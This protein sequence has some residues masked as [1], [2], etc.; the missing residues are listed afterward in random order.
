MIR[1]GCQRSRAGATAGRGQEDLHPF[2][3]LVEL[4]GT[5]AAEANAFFEATE[6]FFE[7]KVAPFQTFNQHAQTRKDLVELDRLGVWRGGFRGHEGL[8]SS[9]LCGAGRSISAPHPG[10]YPVITL[11]NRCEPSTGAIV[12]ASVVNQGIAKPDRK[13]SGRFGLR[14]QI[15]LGLAAVTLIAIL[16]T[17]FLALWAAGAT[18]GVHRETEAVTLTSAAARMVSA[19]VDRQTDIESSESREQLRA[20]LSTLSERSGG[21]QFSV[22]SAGRGVVASWPPRAARDVDPPIANSVVAGSP[23]VIQYR[24]S[25]GGG[26]TQLLAY[27]GI[28]ARGRIVGA[29][30][31]VLDA[32]PPVQVVLRRSGWL[33]LGLVCGDALL[34]LALGYFVLTQMVVRPLR[35][36][37]QATA[38]VGVGDWDQHIDLPGPS[39][40]SALARAFN[41]MTSSLAAQREQLI[42]SEKLAS[43]GQLAAGVAHEIGNPLAAILGYV[44]ILRADL[45]G[46]G[47]L[48]EAERRDALD[49]V[50]A[51]TQRINRII[52]DLLE[53]SRPSHEEPSLVDPLAVVRSAQAL[54]A[55]QARLREVRMT[56][57]P[58]AGPWPTVMVSQ[59]RMTQVLVNL[60]LNA[61]DAMSGKGQVAITCERAAG[62]V[63]IA[64]SDEGPGIERELRR[65]VFDP[66]FTTKPPGQGTGLGLSI[67]R[68][69]VESYGGT[70]ELD[71]EAVRGARFVVDLPAALDAYV[72]PFERT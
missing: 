13:R 53:Y 49:R 55:P 24:D 61:A 48:P 16:T 28:E 69:I 33:L 11:E 71:A 68:S 4:L 64:V 6:P 66:F 32:P 36:M 35:K 21:I 37:E 65:K 23:P 3:R 29:A 27:A 54:L 26:A 1:W 63:R 5:A 51:E 42:R 56:V 31:V 45:A 44:D 50:K 34:V 59:G 40:L 7:S 2:F 9:K 22:L 60:L 19:I 62:R 46:T 25:P 14:A 17:G 43:V 10:P 41:Q 18:L 15:L 58:Q 12:D 8:H 47:A 72:A 38:Q 57:T 67:S 30:R 52:R 20:A 39:E 70:L